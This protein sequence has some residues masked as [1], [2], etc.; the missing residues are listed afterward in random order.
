MKKPA[1]PVKVVASGGWPV[2]LRIPRDAK[3]PRGE[4]PATHTQDHAH[5]R[6]FLP[7]WEKFKEVL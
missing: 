3:T 1:K 5:A 6:D 4:L 7:P 2:R